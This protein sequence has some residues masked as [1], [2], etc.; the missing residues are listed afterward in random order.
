MVRP[1]LA[2]LLVGFLCGP[3]LHADM[4]WD[5]RR[6]KLEPQ[7]IGDA[8]DGTF[9]LKQALSVIG[10]ETGNPLS[11]EQVPESKS[12]EIQ[13]KGKTFWQAVEA[14]EEKYGVGAHQ[15]RP[16][17]VTTLEGLPYYDPEAR[18]VKS[19]I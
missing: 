3:S 12:V 11:L 16:C 14:V 2:S 4:D 5:Q 8:G 17:W 19:Q 6:V 13:L 10:R 15:I 7:T 9:T 18:I 1:L